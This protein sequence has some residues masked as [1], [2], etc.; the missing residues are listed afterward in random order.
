MTLQEILQKAKQAAGNAVSW[1]GDKAGIPEMKVSEWVA[2]GPTKDYNKINAAEPANYN[3]PLNS[4]GQSK[5]IINPYGTTT[6]DTTKTRIVTD[7]GGNGDGGGEPTYDEQGNLV[8][9]ATAEYNRKK[10]AILSRLQMMKDEAQRLRGSAKG[11]FDFTTGEVKKNYEALKNLSKEKLQQ[12]LEGLS[13]ED[14]NVQ[15]TYGRVAGNA[16]RAMESALTRNRMLHRAMGSLGSSFYSN[17]QGD[18]T[19]QGMNTVNDTAVEEAAKRSAI[20]TAKSKTNTD[21]AQNDIAIGAEETKL[22]DDA[23][24]EYND[25]IA[26]ADMLEKNYNIDSTEAIDEADAKLTSSLEAIK[27]YVQDKTLATKASGATTGALGNF[28]KSYDAVTPIKPVLDNTEK[29]QGANNFIAN[30]NKIGTVGSGFNN[31]IASAS[32]NLDQYNPNSPN[33]FLK[34]KKKSVEDPNQYYINPTA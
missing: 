20:G 27:K 31:L 12:A 3:V 19:N 16:R 7:N 5:A 24:K 17:A 8:D 13:L 32:N 22:N 10:N 30:A 21:F 28:V 15:N 4:N 14:T 25:A 26:N 18:T 1:I 11:Q 33:Y 23:M 9:E 6:P 34:P 2:G 29:Y